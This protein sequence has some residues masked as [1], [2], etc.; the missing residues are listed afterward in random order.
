M[1]KEFE[2]VAK[3][4]GWTTAEFEDIFNGENKSFNDYK[5]RL[6][7][8][9]LGAKIANILGIDNRIFR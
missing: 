2:Y 1:T 8:I 4:L 3:K 6:F 5:N 7:L 9:T